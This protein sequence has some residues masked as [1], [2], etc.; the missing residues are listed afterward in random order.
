M[1]NFLG[2]VYL[3]VAC[4]LIALYLISRAAQACWNRL[5][6]KWAQLRRM[7]ALVRTAAFRAGFE[8]R[9]WRH[10]S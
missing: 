2:D 1:W 7:L 5:R 10:P 8:V 6:R 9:S 3:V 4:S